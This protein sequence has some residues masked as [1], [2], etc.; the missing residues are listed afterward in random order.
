MTMARD[1]YIFLIV[2]AVNFI[3]SVAYLIAGV[4][5]VVP[6][7][8][9]LA[10]ENDTEVLYDNRRTYVI[11]FIEMILCPVIVP[12]FFLMGHLFYLYCTSFLIGLQASFFLKISGF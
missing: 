11:R 3:V 9:S 10:D 5:L 2:L 12:L 6:A 8:A 7:R 4:V 1:E